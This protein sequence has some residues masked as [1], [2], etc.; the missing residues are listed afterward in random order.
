MESEMLDPQSRD[1]NSE[2]TTWLQGLQQV[3]QERRRIWDSY[4]H[5]TSRGLWG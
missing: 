5:E 4:Q 1:S 3:G 2:L